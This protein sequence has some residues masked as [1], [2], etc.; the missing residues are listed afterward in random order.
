MAK[1]NP[2]KE[3][4]QTRN[5]DMARTT[6]WGQSVPSSETKTSRAGEPIR[7]PDRR[8]YKPSVRKE[9]DNIRK[10][11]E[12]RMQKAKTKSQKSKTQEHI[13]PKKTKKERER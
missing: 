13:A 11:Q 1:P 3:E 10:E 6:K 7:E 9:L 4:G 8:T 2:T 12:L 5:P